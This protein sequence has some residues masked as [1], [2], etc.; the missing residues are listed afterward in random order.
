MGQEIDTNLLTTANHVAIQ[1]ATHNTIIMIF[2]SGS[3]PQVT[4]FRP[5]VLY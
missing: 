2:L 5:I 4:P 1:L 3:S